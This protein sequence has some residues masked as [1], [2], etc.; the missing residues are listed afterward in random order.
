MKWDDG[1]RWRPSDSAGSALV[2]VVASV[3]WAAVTMVTAVLS[4]FLL[5]SRPGAGADG[6]DDL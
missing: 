4:L 2:L 3:W 6:N 1:E 5:F